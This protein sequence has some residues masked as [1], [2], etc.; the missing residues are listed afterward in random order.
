MTGELHRITHGRKYE[1][2][3]AG[4][5]RIFRRD[6]Y[7]GASVDDIA[8]EAGVSKATLYHY[9]PDKQLMFAAVVREDLERRQVDGTGMVRTDLPIDQA[10][11]FAGKLIAAHTVSEIGVSTARLV[12]AEA[13]RFPEL[14]AKYYMTRP[15]AFR[16][17]LEEPI[18]YWQEKGL[19]RSDIDD[20]DMAVESFICLCMAGLRERAL[21]VGRLSIDEAVIHATVE[22]AITMFLCRYGTEAARSLIEYQ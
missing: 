14:S 3:L 18:R 15:A 8:R 22:N 9:L 16:S 13:E 7:K 2:V 5:L 19:L 1:Q 11:R 10:L 17:A 6:G 12:I 4:A 20:L 21:L